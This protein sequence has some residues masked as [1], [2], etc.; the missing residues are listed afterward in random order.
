M[1]RNLI[2]EW[3]A[4]ENSSRLAITGYAED[5]LSISLTVSDPYREG[6]VQFSWNENR[7]VI[8]GITETLITK[9]G[10]LDVEMIVSMALSRNGSI[11]FGWSPYNEA[12]CALTL[13]QGEEKIMIAE[14][15]AVEFLGG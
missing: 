11:V 3:S 12:E 8:K 10:P 13:S 6:T 14:T 15:Y 5:D 4:G 1:E 7:F 9:H 2:S